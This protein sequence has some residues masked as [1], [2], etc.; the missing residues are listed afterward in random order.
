MCVWWI[1]DIWEIGEGGW[2]RQV[3]EPGD[4]GGWTSAGLEQDRCR[5]PAEGSMGLSTSESYLLRWE[6]KVLS[7]ACLDLH[8]CVGNHKETAEEPVRL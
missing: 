5:L 8:I 2:R 4:G 1:R 6:L 7:T 3:A